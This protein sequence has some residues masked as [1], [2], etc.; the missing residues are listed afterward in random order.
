[1]NKRSFIK[2]TVIGAMLGFVAGLLLAPNSGQET[3]DEIRRRT[4]GLAGDV[5]KRANKLQDQLGSKVDQLREVAK[6]LGSE[7]R[8][9]SQSLIARAEVMKQDLSSSTKQLTEAG[10]GAKDNTIA[11]V[12]TLVDE[13][14]TLMGEL[15]DVTKRLFKSAKDRLRQ[16][17]LADQAAV[18]RIE[19]LERQGHDTDSEA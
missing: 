7:A 3:R 15:E 4:K 12:K 1:M 13:G 10:R 19:Q 5:G 2:G 11:S 17:K 8:E 6:D 18:A 14:A 16:Q 9:E